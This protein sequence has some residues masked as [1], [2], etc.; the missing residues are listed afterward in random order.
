VERLNNLTDG[1]VDKSQDN[2][3]SRT[4]LRQPPHSCCR[5]C[6][7]ALLVAVCRQLVPRRENAIRPADEREC[8]STINNRWTHDRCKCSKIDASCFINTTTRYGVADS[9]KWLEPAGSRLADL[10]QYRKWPFS[11]SMTHTN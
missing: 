11:G 4:S 1:N 7:P 5:R 6:H 9:G 2:S 8:R 3:F 10:V